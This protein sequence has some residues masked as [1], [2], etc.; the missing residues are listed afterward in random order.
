MWRTLPSGYQASLTFGE[1]LMKV[2]LTETLRAT[3]RVV[4][5]KK[6]RHLL[7]D[8]RRNPLGRVGYSLRYK[9]I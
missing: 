2:N 9:G 8:E 4:S 5:F 3:L 1:F 6:T 7:G